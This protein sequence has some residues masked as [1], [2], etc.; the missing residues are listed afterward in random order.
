MEIRFFLIVY[1]EDKNNTR[2]TLFL[3]GAA[4]VDAFIY[5]FV[6][7]GSSS[8]FYQVLDLTVDSNRLFHLVPFVRAALSLRRPESLGTKTSWSTRVLTS[9]N[10]YLA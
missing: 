8:P 7:L 9:I 3:T 4:P 6:F 5:F 10:R 1:S 2:H